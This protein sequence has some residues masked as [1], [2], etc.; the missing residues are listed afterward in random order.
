MRIAGVIA[1]T[2]L[3]AA[4]SQSVGGQA[5][6]SGSP[7]SAP[8]GNTAHRP[9]RP[10]SHSPPG[11]Q[12]PATGRGRVDRG[13]D[14]VGRGGHRRS[15]RL[16]RGVLRRPDHSARRRHRVHRPLRAPQGHDAA[17]HHRREVQRWRPGV[18]GGTGLPR[19]PS[20]GSRGRVEGGLD[21]LLRDE[22]TDRIT[23]RRSRP[24]HHG[25]ALLDG[26]SLGVRRQPMPH[27]LSTG[28]LCVDYAHRLAW[29]DRQR[30][31]VLPLAAFSP[32]H[33]RRETGAAFS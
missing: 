15:R 5:E 21:R 17:A 9:P 33:R 31:A 32:C 6:P 24:V 7:Q 28:L 13:G 30:P 3:V 19:S 26:Q 29:S 8:P 16:S 11:R 4:C 2:A 14:R 20:L 1:V 12:P 22:P 27:R 18:P 10:S 25:L 23:P